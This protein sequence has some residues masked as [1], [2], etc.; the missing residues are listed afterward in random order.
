MYDK[1]ISSVIVLKP[2]H[3]NNINS[4]LINVHKIL[5]NNFSHFEIILVNNCMH[6]DIRELTNDLGKNIKEILEL[7]IFLEKY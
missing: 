3:L 5:E 6:R 2:E 1:F 4:Y 7:L